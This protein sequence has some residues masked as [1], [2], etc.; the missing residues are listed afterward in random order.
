MGQFIS[1]LREHVATPDRNSVKVK[2]GAQEVSL[3]ATPLT[4]TDLDRLMKRHPNFASAPT[5]TATVDLL[6][7]K[8]QT[9]AGDLAFDLADK[10]LL[11]K[12]PLEWING[13][14]AKLFPEQ[15]IDLSDAAVDD[16]VGN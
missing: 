5:V 1:A 10:P 13:V 6:I 11:L 2:I 9:E 8:C 12:M 16:E 14:R 4:G 3:Y 7:A 15:D